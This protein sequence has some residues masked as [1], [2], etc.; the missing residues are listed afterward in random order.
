VCVCVDVN[1]C[2]VRVFLCAFARVVDVFIGLS[3]PPRFSPALP[4]SF[5]PSQSL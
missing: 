5:S 2:V 4:S 1:V 3:L